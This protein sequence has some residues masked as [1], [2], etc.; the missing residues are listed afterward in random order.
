M[1]HRC[2]P[3]TELGASRPHEEGFSQ[4]FHFGHKAEFLDLV[5]TG[6]EMRTNA[7]V[8]LQGCRGPV[9][10]VA[11]GNGLLLSW[12]TGNHTRGP[13]LEITF[14]WVFSTQLGCHR[15]LPR[16]SPFMA[17]LVNGGLG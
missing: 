9:C 5:L 8:C 14:G 2:C 4:I 10:A 3:G 17:P 7:W 1:R 6:E 15:T 12:P 13:T 11:C 16:E